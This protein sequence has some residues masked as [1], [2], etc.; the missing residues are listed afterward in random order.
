MIDNTI[1][2]CIYEQI[3]GPKKPSPVRTYGMGPTPKDIKTSNNMSVA[4]KQAFDDAVNEKVEA[5]RIQ[6]SAEI[7]AKLCHFK[8]DLISHFEERIHKR[9]DYIT[10]ISATQI[11]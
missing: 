3:I 1:K 7:D 5:M 4:Q 9:N 2:D 8:E 10:T 11:I 6:M